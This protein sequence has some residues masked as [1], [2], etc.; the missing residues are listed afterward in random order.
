MHLLDTDTLT[1]LHAG[2]PRV[3]KHLRDLAD[4]DVG[5][6]IITKIE[7]LRGRFDFVL[8][9]ATGSELLRAQQLLAR[10]E[11]L[12]AQIVIVPVGQA[13]AVRFDRLRAM[14]KLR[15]IGRADLLIASIALAHRATLVTRNVRHFKQVPGLTVTNWVD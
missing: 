9:A 6:T 7:V 1:Y 11:D 12:L 14:K 8:K 13:A 15:K 2:N 3:V 10:T 5:T 4:P